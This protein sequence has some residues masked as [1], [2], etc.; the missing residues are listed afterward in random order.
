MRL[1]LLAFLT[2][3][4][5]ATAATFLWLHGTIV[6]RGCEPGGTGYDPDTAEVFRGFECADG[7]VILAPTGTV[8]PK[9]FVPGNELSA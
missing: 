4:A 9:H 6:V 8:A 1:T 2:G 3:V 5:I 7:L